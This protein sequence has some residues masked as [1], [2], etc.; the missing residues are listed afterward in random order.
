MLVQEGPQRPR[1]V[2]PARGEWL[3]LTEQHRKLAK[4]RVSQQDPTGFNGVGPIRRAA[5]VNPA[6]IYF[7]F[8][9]LACRNKRQQVYRCDVTGSDFKDP[10]GSLDRQEVKD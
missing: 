6:E 1:I 4:G 5:C 8:P 2:S 7:A 9:A 10:L 3:S